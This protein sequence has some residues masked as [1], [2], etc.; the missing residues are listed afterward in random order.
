MANRHPAPLKNPGMLAPV[1]LLI[2]IDRRRDL[3]PL[4]PDQASQLT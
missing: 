4:P 1:N 3:A 2:E